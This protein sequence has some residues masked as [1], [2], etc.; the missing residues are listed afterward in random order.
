LHHLATKAC[1]D[2]QGRPKLMIFRS[3]EN[4]CATSY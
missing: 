4:L 2:L 1:T 3:F